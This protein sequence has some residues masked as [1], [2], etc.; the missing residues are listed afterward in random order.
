LALRFRGVDPQRFLNRLAPACGWIFSRWFFAASLMFMATALGL[1]TVHLD[2]LRQRL[3]D[4]QAFFGAHNLLWLA[5]AV[6]LAKVLHELGHALACQRFGGE[7]H[8]IGV[9]LLVFTPCLY[10]NVSDA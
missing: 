6:A 8:E 10:C 3:P 2:T 5:A 1:V 4:F 9:M 7:C